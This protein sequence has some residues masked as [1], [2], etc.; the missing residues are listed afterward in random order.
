MCANRAMQSINATCPLALTTVCKTGGYYFSRDGWV[1][2][3]F[4]LTNSKKCVKLK[5]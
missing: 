3:F 5:I 1:S 2:S 4:M